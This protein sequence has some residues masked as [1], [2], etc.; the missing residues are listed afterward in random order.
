MYFNFQFSGWIYSFFYQNK[1]R[2]L[3]CMILYPSTKMDSDVGNLNSSI[4]TKLS[5]WTE[6]FQTPIK[7]VFFV[8][9]FN[10][11]FGSIGNIKK[12]KRRLFYWQ[13]ILFARDLF[14][15][16]QR[17][18]SGFN[19]IPKFMFFPIEKSAASIALYC[20]ALHFVGLFSLQRIL[21]QSNSTCE[22]FRFIRA[23][24]IISL[25]QKCEQNRNS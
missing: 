6:S 9:L 23:W 12:K 20:I 22:C 24:K 13:L 17:A 7:L 3:I 4:L 8:S 16:C 1:I 5:I 2:A 18:I 15:R 10:A 14:H 19:K 11:T 21:H 25:F